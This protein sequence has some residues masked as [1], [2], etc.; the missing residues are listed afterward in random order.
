MRL[1]NKRFALR[2]A[3]FGFI[4]IVLLAGPVYGLYTLLA[5]DTIET[6]RFIAV[7]AIFAG[8]FGFFVTPLIAFVALSEQR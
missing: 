8:V 5:D 7:K 3:Q 2:A 4:G 6:V 1:I